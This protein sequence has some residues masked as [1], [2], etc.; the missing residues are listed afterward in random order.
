[1]R[2]M[3]FTPAVLLLSI[4]SIAHADIV[5]S[6]GNTPGGDNVLFNTGSDIIGPATTL[7]GH[8]AN[9]T[10]Q[11]DI[12]G[13]ENLI[14]NNAGGGQATVEGV[15]GGFTT[16]D[17]FLTIPPGGVYTQ[18]VFALSGDAQSS[19]TFKIT[20]TEG[21]GTIQTSNDFT[22]SSGNDFFTVVAINGQDIRNVDIT[23]SAGEIDTLKQIR[24]GG[25]D[26]SNPPNAVPEPTSIVLLSSLVGGIALLRKR[27]AI[28]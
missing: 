2:L 3:K 26:S 19:S 11:V 7:R 24:I 15:D 23:T 4:G 17:I 21:D 14:V 16:A 20:V 9:T 25:F 27:L 8:I 28:C 13:S 6:G 10:R 12:V 22:F 5:F 18:I 1:M